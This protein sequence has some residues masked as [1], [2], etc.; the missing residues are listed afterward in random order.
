MKTS[1][2]FT[3]ALSATSYTQAHW[4]FHGQLSTFLLNSKNPAMSLSGIFPSNRTRNYGHFG[5]N[6][7]FSAEFIAASVVS[8]SASIPEKLYT[9]LSIVVYRGE[10]QLF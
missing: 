10:I 9:F 3:S 7:E 8:K 6:G 4:I 1:C 2:A 5:D